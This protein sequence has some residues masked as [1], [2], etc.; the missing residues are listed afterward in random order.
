VDQ[1]YVPG[2]GF[3]PFPLNSGDEGEEKNRCF[4][5]EM[6]QNILD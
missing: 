1:G 2:E 3:F 6:E 4:Y 5:I